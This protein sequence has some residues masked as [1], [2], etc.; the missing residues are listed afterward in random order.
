MKI[1]LAA[2]NDEMVES[3]QT[4]FADCEDVEIHNGSILDLPCSAVISPANSFGF[5]DGGIDLQYL[6]HF[7]Q[8]LQSRLQ[9]R[10][11]IRHGGELLVGQALILETFHKQI[12]Y[13]ISAPSMRVPQ[14]LNNSVNVYLATKAVLSLVK[15]GVFPDGDEEGKL[16]SESLTSI[17]F[18]G[19]GT[20]VGGITPKQCAAQMKAAYDYVYAE[21]P[22]FPGTIS[23]ATDEHNYLANIN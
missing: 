11:V 8:S 3:W 10:I 4:V 6:L 19:I 15:K 1:Y 18:P 22:E 20:G 23:E 17:A 16:I 7:G 9:D 21:R 13:L 2:L 12:P 14:Q 5:M